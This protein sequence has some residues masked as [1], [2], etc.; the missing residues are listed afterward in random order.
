MEGNAS[1]ENRSSPPEINPT[2]CTHTWCLDPPELSTWNRNCFSVEKMSVPSL[3]SNFRF[4]S[5]LF[6]SVR[7]P[8]H[9][10]QETLQRT[11]KRRNEV[12]HCLRMMLSKSHVLYIA[13]LVSSLKNE[14]NAQNLISC[15]VNSCHSLT[16]NISAEIKGCSQQSRF[17]PH[18]PL[19]CAGHGSS[20]SY[21]DALKVLVPSRESTNISACARCMRVGR[22]SRMNR[23]SEQKH[24]E[25]TFQFFFEC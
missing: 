6:S 14:G 9:G 4:S 11:K 18:R 19:N 5:L 25:L 15:S 21:P 17:R 3:R 20:G 22:K 10:V 24:H 16:G 13:S 7:S 2:K 1:I 8:Q 23:R 12:S